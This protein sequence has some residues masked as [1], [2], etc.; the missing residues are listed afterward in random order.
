MPLNFIGNA[1]FVNTSGANNTGSDD[2]DYYR[3]DFP[4]HPDYMY[5]VRGRLY[6]LNNNNNFGTLT[7]D[8][9][10]AFKNVG[11]TW[12]P[13]YDDNLLATGG[14]FFVRSGEVLFYVRPY[15]AGTSG[16]YYL[17]L[18][19]DR[20][21]AFDLPCGA[22]NL[23]VDGQPHTGFSNANASPNYYNEPGIPVA[24]DCNTQWCGG[25]AE[26]RLAHSVW[27]T[28][29]APA[30]GSVEISTCGL[31]DFDTQLALY[32]TNNCLNVNGYAFLAA[33]DDG[34]GC[35]GYTSELSMTGL[36]PGQTYY[37]LVDG[38][39]DQTGNLGIKITDLTTPVNYIAATPDVLSA[40][41]NPTSGTLNILLKGEGTIAGLVLSDV[42]GKTV[43]SRQTND[44]AQSAELDLRALPDGVYLLQV[45]TDERTYTQKILVQK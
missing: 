7:N 34:D 21:P 11:Y 40:S 26:P 41:P 4:Y 42:S 43:L 29:Q 44:Q 27:F 35:S 10:W 23:P 17:E 9:I 28:F 25:E 15:F 2:E 13:P 1:A 8:C 38:Y 37:V 16:T 39:E 18:E 20:I 32:Q 33:N 14:E 24:G 19:I 6:D 12:S 45:R 5:R 22:V 3:I 31:A 30:S 36:T